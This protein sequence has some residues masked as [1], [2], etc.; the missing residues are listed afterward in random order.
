M[1][2]KNNLFVI[3]ENKQAKQIIKNK[4]IRNKG[5]HTSKAVYKR[6]K[7]QYP[8]IW[9]YII[10]NI[11]DPQIIIAIEYWLNKIPKFLGLILIFICALTLMLPVLF[12]YFFNILLSLIA[13]FFDKNIR[14][15]CTE[16][17]EKV[18]SK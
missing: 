2:L 15:E 10:I 5:Y 9:D 18:V 7:L 8:S 17:Y 11:F 16:Y 14:K 4:M 6:M 1:S 12:L 13:Y 3:F